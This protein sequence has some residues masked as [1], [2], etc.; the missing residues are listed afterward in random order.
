MYLSRILELLPTLLI[1]IILFFHKEMYRTEM[2]LTGFL[3]NKW[4]ISI[5]ESILFLRF[6]NFIIIA[7]ATDWNHRVPFGYSI[8]FPFYVICRDK[9]LY[10]N[11][12]GECLSF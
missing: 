4:G 12:I 6:N 1:N 11:L 7:L 9:L 5:V 3:C 8:W 10:Q 2:Y